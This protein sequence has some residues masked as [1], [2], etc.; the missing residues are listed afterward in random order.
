MLG[1]ERRV[2]AAVTAQAASASWRMQPAQC[3]YVTACKD[4]QL[5]SLIAGSFAC[6]FA[7]SSARELTGGADSDALMT[8]NF[9]CCSKADA[10]AVEADGCRACELICASLVATTGAPSGHWKRAECSGVSER[11]WEWCGVAREPA[12]AGLGVAILELAGRTDA[13]TQKWLARESPQ[14]GGALK[15]RK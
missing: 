5:L 6:T 10:T 14:C 12:G 11:E 2:R 7:S 15:W 8:R 3:A 13:G 9:S 1:N 4:E